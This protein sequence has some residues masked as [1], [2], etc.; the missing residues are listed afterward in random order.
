MPVW[1]QFLTLGSEAA[2]WRRFQQTLA[3]RYDE[4]AFMPSSAAAAADSSARERDQ[5]QQTATQADKPGPQP[6]R[7]SA[8][9]GM[10]HPVRILS[11]VPSV[12]MLLLCYYV[13]MYTLLFLSR[14]PT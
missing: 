7:P 3:N 14:S 6:V 9:P 13:I 11:L 8:G 1:W 2:L 5:D 4:D 10:P 12:I